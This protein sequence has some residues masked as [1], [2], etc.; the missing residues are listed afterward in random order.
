MSRDAVFLDLCNRMGHDNEKDL[1]E[2]FG[3][4]VSYP[5]ELWTALGEDWDQEL[6]DAARSHLLLSTWNMYIFTTCFK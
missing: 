6:L 5:S 1:E 4:E 3:D 2:L